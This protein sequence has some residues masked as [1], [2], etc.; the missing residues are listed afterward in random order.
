MAATVVD[1]LTTNL[2]K[3]EVE[4]IRVAGTSSNVWTLT[5]FREALVQ[6]DIKKFNKTG[7]N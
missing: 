7:M 4:V 5:D 3:L 6:N 2:T 1:P